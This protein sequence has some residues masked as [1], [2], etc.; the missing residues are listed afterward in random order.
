MNQPYL[1][2]YWD[3]VKN[4]QD[5]ITC[6]ANTTQEAVNMFQRGIKK[7]TYKI[8][9]VWQPADDWTAEKEVIYD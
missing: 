7:G 3:N 6:W 8:M 4:A 1:V 9:S 2:L 5:T